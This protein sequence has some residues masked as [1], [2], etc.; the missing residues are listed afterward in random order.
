MITLYVSCVAR[1]K[2][3]SFKNFFNLFVNRRDPVEPNAEQQSVNKLP[4]F[5]VPVDGFV[6]TVR[7]HGLVLW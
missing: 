3:C 1:F 4:D 6:K 7:P 2:L 5:D